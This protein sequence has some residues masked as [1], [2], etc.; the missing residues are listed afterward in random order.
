MQESTGKDNKSGP[1]SRRINQHPI[2]RLSLP[3]TS[4]VMTLNRGLSE[5]LHNPATQSHSYTFNI[6]TEIHIDD[7]AIVSQHVDKNCSGPDP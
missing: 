5:L 2:T 6:V 3:T 1:Y 7:I 4:Y